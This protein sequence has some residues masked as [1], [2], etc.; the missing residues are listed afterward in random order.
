MAAQKNYEIR[1]KRLAAVGEQLSENCFEL[2]PC[3]LS[4]LQEGE[5]RVRLHSASMD[6]AFR[7]KMRAVPLEKYSHPIR[8]T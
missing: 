1:V 7:A 2:C 8:V 6:P 5:V 3:E 4:D